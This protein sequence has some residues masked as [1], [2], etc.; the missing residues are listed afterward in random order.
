MEEHFDLLGKVLERFEKAKLKSN[1]VEDPLFRYV[2]TF[3]I[4]LPDSN[5][6]ERQ[7]QDEKLST[8]RDHQPPIIYF[9]GFAYLSLFCTPSPQKN[10]PQEHLRGIG[11]RVL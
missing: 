3:L 2:N 5:F 7:K 6:I 8:I 9:R 11:E 4:A 10:I 1:L